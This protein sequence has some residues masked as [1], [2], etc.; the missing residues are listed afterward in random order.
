MNSECHSQEHEKQKDN[1]KAHIVTGSCLIHKRDQSF[2]KNPLIFFIF[3]NSYLLI[4]KHFSFWCYLYFIVIC[5]I[6]SD[7]YQRNC[8]RRFAHLLQVTCTL[9]FIITAK[10]HAYFLHPQPHTFYNISACT[11]NLQTYL[12]FHTLALLQKNTCISNICPQLSTGKMSF[13]LPQ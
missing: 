2:A 4:N 12:T 8:L 11:S 13:A 5:T 6:C 9:A 3:S 7:F 10:W 1:T